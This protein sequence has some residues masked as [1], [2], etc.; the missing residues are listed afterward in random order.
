MLDGKRVAVV[1]PAFDEERL[2]GETIRGIPEFV[3]RIVVV[4][5][6][7]RD[8]TAA[9]AEAVGD[10]RVRIIRHERNAGVGAAIATGLSPSA[11]GGDRRHL[12][13]GRRQPDGPGGAPGAGR[14]GRAW[15]GRVREG[16]P[17]RVGRG[18]E[19]H[20]AH[21]LSRERRP[22]APD[23][24]RV[25]L[26]ACR[27]L[28]GGVHGALADCAPA[29][30]PRRALPALR[31]PERR[32]RPSQHPERARARR[33]LAADLRRRR[34]LGASSFGRSCRGSRGSC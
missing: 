27:R 24:D 1:V 12:R 14:P 32:A 6:A 20:P 17:P 16:E 4:D 8:G 5:D 25:R 7:S 9:A 31:V 19:G 13:H 22:L 28:S 23:Q 33:S 34:A 29:P 11:R 3:D 15:R 18:L 21:A 26:L 30:R 2:V 10:A